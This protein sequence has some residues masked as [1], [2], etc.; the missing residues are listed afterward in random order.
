[1]AF[2]Y[3]KQE[4]WQNSMLPKSVKLYARA[5]AYTTIFF[6]DQLQEVQAQYLFHQIVDRKRQIF[7]G[8]RHVSIVDL[9]SGALTCTCLAL[10][11]TEQMI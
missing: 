4:T 9:R 6:F 10:V 2:N 8:Y 11:V 7:Q 1:M 5:L 3:A